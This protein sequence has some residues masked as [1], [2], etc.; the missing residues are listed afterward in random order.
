MQRFLKNNI[1]KENARERLL[2]QFRDMAEM[3]DDK[4]TRVWVDVEGFEGRY[5]V[6]QHG[7]VMTAERLT[8][9][10]IRGGACLSP[11]Y[12]KGYFVVTL[13]K[14]GVQKF[15]SVHRLVAKA[16]LVQLKGKDQINHI[17]RVKVNNK[18]WNLEWCTHQENMDHANSTLAPSY[19]IDVDI[20]RP[21]I[22][23]QSLIS[24]ES[25]S[26]SWV[27]RPEGT[28]GRLELP[29]QINTEGYIG[30]T[31]HAARDI[32]YGTQS[33]EV[34]FLSLKYNVPKEIIQKVIDGELYGNV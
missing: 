18:W 33:Y 13:R 6:S 2:P 21:K 25:L 32:K 29:I 7:E 5:K 28:G 1:N 11:R 10:G 19:P 34:D 14:H 12:L 15:A 30:L 26:S 16:F 9:E 27:E 4:G 24:P 31:V 17:D 3:D 8:P 22:T 23:T 20:Y